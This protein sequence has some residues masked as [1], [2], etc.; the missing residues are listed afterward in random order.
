MQTV[1][2]AG[3]LGTRIS[4]ESHLRPKPMIEIGGKPILWHIMKHYSIYGHTNFLILCGYKGYLIKEYFCNFFRHNSDLTVDFSNGNIEIH[5]NSFDS[6]KVTMVDTGEYTQTGG[7]ILKSK[8]YLE[9]EFFLT[10][11]DG[12]SDVNLDSLYERHRTSSN[13]VTLTGIRPRARYG[14]ILFDDEHK[15]SKFL[16]KPEGDSQWING[17]FMVCK[18]DILKYLKNEDSILEKEP[19]EK[20]ASERKLGVYE[21]SEFWMAMDTLRDKN[22]LEELWDQAKAPWKTWKE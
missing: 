19:L 22:Y 15:I 12:V 3:G 14:S 20:L 2:L 4:E 10:Y 17:G 1:I 8:P 16:E 6:W 13:L 9:D 18:K 21:H 5:K 11:G 7:R